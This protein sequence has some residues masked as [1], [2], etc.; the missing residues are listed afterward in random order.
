MRQYLKSSL[1]F[2]S[3]FLALFISYHELKEVIPSDPIIILEIEK[4]K[5]PHDMP[6]YLLTGAISDQDYLLESV[7]LTPYSE[8]IVKR[9]T[10]KYEHYTKEVSLKE[11]KSAKPYTYLVSRELLQKKYGE[12]NSFSFEFLDE[13]RFT[14]YFQFEGVETDKTKFEC[15]VRSVDHKNIP[16][17]VREVGYLSLFR[18]IPWYFLA[19][20][21][22]ILL[23]VIIEVIDIFFKRGGKKTRRS[24]KNKLITDQD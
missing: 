18:G 10:F 7:R 21:V 14:F 4:I 11:I 2:F 22:G 1:E 15:R 6:A 23:I 20:L 13:E 24:K 3:I 8:N 16:C 5:T 9:A 12:D 17:E 19:V